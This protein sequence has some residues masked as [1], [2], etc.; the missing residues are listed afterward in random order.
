VINNSVIKDLISFYEEIFKIFK[1]YLSIPI[2]S[3]EADRAFSVLKL[4]KTWLR[5]S[6][7]DERL[8][9]LAVIKMACD[10]KIDYDFLRIWTSAKRDFLKLCFLDLDFVS[11]KLVGVDKIKYS[12]SLQKLYEDDFETFMYYNAVDSVL[13]QKIH[14][15]R[16]YISIILINK[17]IITNLNRNFY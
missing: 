11:N 10:F 6:M 5:T 16:N 1:L 15:A 4:L 7:E 8:S 14:E 12:G 13:V 2:S 17:F 3:A 9:D